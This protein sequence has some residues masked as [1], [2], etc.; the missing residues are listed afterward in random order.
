EGPPG[1]A[2]IR[3]GLSVMLQLGRLKTRCNGMLAG[4]PLKTVLERVRGIDFIV[5]VTV[6]RP[7]VG[8]IR[9]GKGN[10]GKGRRGFPR[11]QSL[12]ARLDGVI[13]VDGGTP[14]RYCQ[15]RKNKACLVH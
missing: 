10:D 7:S 11:G 8:R 1:L 15:P 2:A 13:A 6:R 4:Y 14:D 3:V 12:D 9:T 5:G